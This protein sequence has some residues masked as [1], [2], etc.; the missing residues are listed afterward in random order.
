MPPAA[1]VAETLIDG[2]RKLCGINGD[3]VTFETAAGTQSVSVRESDSALEVIASCGK[4]ETETVF[5]WVA[6][7]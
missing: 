4:T 3:R 7:G 2:A 6:A 1:Q 5:P